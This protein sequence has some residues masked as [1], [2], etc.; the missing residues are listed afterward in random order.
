MDETLRRQVEQRT[1]STLRERRLKNSLPKP[2]SVNDV[3]LERMAEKDLE[4]DAPKTGYPDLDGIIKGF[5]P[6]H[7]Y[8]LTGNENV[9]KTSLACNFAVRIARQ[10]KSVLYFALEPENTVVDYIASVRTDKRFDE[11]TPEDIQEDDGNIHIYGKEEVRTLPELVQI[12]DLSERYDLIIIDHIGYFVS[13]TQNLVQEQ[14]NAIKQL[15]G[16]AK[17]KKCAIMMIAHLRK[18]PQGVKKSYVPT[19]DDISGSGAFKQDSTEVMIVVRELEDENADGL[20]YSNQGKL[21]VTKTKAGPNGF[22]SIQFA[23]QKANIM[24]LGELL[25]RR[26]QRLEQGSVNFEKINAEKFEDIDEK[27]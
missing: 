25:A 4:V 6:G 12:V 26:N 16:L 14:S 10:G 5:I 15:A 23:E 18:R 19:S 27:W 21:H 13:G 3:A 9:G 1:V 7:L 2:R 22:I 17:R 20:Q 24:S 8:T 11:I